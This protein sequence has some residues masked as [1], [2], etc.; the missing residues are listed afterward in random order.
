MLVFFLKKRFGV[1]EVVFFIVLS[2]LLAAFLFLLYYKN[3]K[4]KEQCRTLEDK[5]EC[6]LHETQAKTRIL[7]HQN[8]LISMSEMMENIAH[9][10]RQPLSQ[11]NSAVLV[12][13]DLLYEK[14]VKDSVIEEKLLEIESLTKYMS[15]TIDD[16]KDFFNQNKS[17]EY[18]NLQDLVEKSIYIVRG[19]LKSHNIEIQSEIDKSIRCYGYPSELQQVIVVILNNA[20]DMF[21]SRNIFRPKIEIDVEQKEGGIQINICDNGGGIDE[22]IR[23]KIFE[24]YFTTKHKSQGTG[25]GLYISKMIIEES[26]EGS[27]DLSV[28][29]YGACFHIQIKGRYE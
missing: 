18:F 16:F 12:I 25:L 14:E 3:Y 13:D 7:H 26:M 11:I 10:W 27:L 24:P 17:K 20:K 9:Q 19:T 4:L 22:N 29:K 15:K 8:K 2:T 5:I 28:N 23:E 1:L 6:E 21:L